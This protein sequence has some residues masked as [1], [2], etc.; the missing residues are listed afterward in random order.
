M[1]KWPMGKVRDTGA[2]PADSGRSPESAPVTTVLLVDDDPIVRHMVSDLLR[3]RSFRVL[4]AEHVHEALQIA[5]AHAAPIHLLLTDVV[6]PGM[7]GRN[8]ADE[9]MADRPE[10]KVLYMSGYSSDVLL[11]Q[12]VATGKTFI[13]KPFTGEQLDLKLREILGPA[14]QVS[15]EKPA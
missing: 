15:G 1:L 3:I 6:M 12:G 11:Q 8:L 4:K 2:V 5:K 7:G 13:Q 9:L 14:R 10:M